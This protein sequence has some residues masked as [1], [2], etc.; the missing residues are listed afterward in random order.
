[1]NLSDIKNLHDLFVHSTRKFGVNKAFYNLNGEGYTYSEF[2]IKT[3]QVAHL[4]HD[5]GLKTGDKVAIL[6]QNTSN[7]PVAFFSITAFSKVAV[8]L[9]PDFSTDEISNIL[10]HSESKAIFISNKLLNKL[11]DNA[12]NRLSI[13]IIIDTFEILKG[14]IITRKEPLPNTE[15]SG[16]ATIIYTS[17]TTGNSKGVMLS[18]KNWCTNLVAAESLRP[19]HYWDV[20]LSFLPLSHAYEC[21]L[22]LILPMFNGASV[23]YIEKPPTA[24]V[25]LSALKQVRPTTILSVP[26]IIEKLYRNAVLPKFH[27]NGLIKALYQTAPGRKV[28]HYL[29][30]K[31]LKQQ[32]GGR[33]R[34]FGIGGAKLDGKVERFLLEA[35]FPY[36]IGYGLTETSPLLAGANPQMVK[37]Q[38]TGPAVRGVTLRIDNPNPLTG[39]GEIVAK[40]NNIMMGYYKN[41]EATAAAFTSDG[42]FKTKDLGFID[43]KHRVYIRGRLGN[44][45]LGST[46]E[47]IYPE[48]IESVINNHEIVEESIVIQRD[49]KLVALINLNAEKL[50]TFIEE[51]QEQAYETAQQRIEKLI[52][53]VQIFVNSRVNKFSRITAIEVLSE[54]FEK[55]PTLKIKRYLYK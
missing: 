11:S 19:S 8:P 9:L 48:E 33:L 54:Q 5:C 7:W 51:K 37:W 34:F 17:G 16:L 2:K 45:I 38:S 50:K 23:Y 35:K 10:E 6:S 1:M 44:M 53:E 25:L 3:E 40:G 22:G 18:H 13:I 28:L 12:K 30:G 29:A 42:W 32:F 31:K 46:G 24:S 14:K 49:G 39:E 47:N 55:T 26:L 20:W 21:S 36:G 15:G 4:L 52:A 27:K 43:K 41:P